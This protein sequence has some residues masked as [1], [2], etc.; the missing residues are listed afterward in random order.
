MGSESF[1]LGAVTPRHMSCVRDPDE[2]ARG[3]SAFDEVLPP[4]PFPFGEALARGVAVQ[5][6]DELVLR[7]QCWPSCCRGEF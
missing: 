7:F 3:G 1:L 6:A 4:L 5:A 2:E